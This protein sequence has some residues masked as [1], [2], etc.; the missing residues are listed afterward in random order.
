MSAD[1]R[2]SGRTSTSI[3]STSYGQHCLGRPNGEPMYRSDTLRCDADSCSESLPTDASSPGRIS[4]IRVCPWRNSFVILARSPTALSPLLPQT[5]VRSGF[6]SL[7]MSVCLN[8]E[9]ACPRDGC[10]SRGDSLVIALRV[11]VWRI[12]ISLPGQG[13]SRAESC[14]ALF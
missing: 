10:Q 4:L 12:V 8:T 3:P 13:V 9:E 14:C 5:L 7:L 6:C 1:L 2:S 11:E